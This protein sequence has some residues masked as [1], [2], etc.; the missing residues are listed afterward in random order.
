MRPVSNVFSEA[1]FA[2]TFFAR[3][4]HAAIVA[5]LR[6]TA[7]TGA[8]LP[9]PQSKEAQRAVL[10]HSVENVMQ[11]TQPD[12][13]GTEET[14]QAAPPVSSA[15][16][17]VAES[18]LQQGNIKEGSDRAGSGDLTGAGTRQAG[19]R[20]LESLLAADVVQSA[21]DDA[22]V[23]VTA[24]VAPGPLSSAPSS[25]GGGGTQ[26]RPPSSSS[27]SES[28]ML[29]WRARNGLE[30]HL[31][32]RAS[33]SLM[34]APP[35][36]GAAAAAA[37]AVVAPTV[38]GSPAAAGVLGAPTPQTAQAI[39][40]GRRLDASLATAAPDDAA[41]VVVGPSE[42]LA[43]EAVRRPRQ[44]PQPPPPPCTA[45]PSPSRC[46]QAPHLRQLKV[47]RG[48]NLAAA[49]PSVCWRAVRLT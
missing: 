24:V 23:D 41:A 19:S 17:I 20:F 37:A 8:S 6:S 16:A 13:E 29:E 26:N 27:E 15:H 31:P 10:S 21:I 33:L 9:S 46:A 14:P 45:P 38:E 18:A 49:T 43:W 44:P 11:P 30:V 22:L 3:A 2:Q 36:A 32:P 4:T 1:Q 35:Q 39:A 47:G 12:A 5:A 34:E 7:V 25:G 40:L 42:T 28:D 48:N